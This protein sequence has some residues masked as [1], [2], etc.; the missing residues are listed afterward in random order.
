M[1]IEKLFKKRYIKEHI[2]LPSKR[3]LYTIVSNEEYW[4]EPNINFCS[5]KGYY[6]KHKNGKGICNHLKLLALINDNMIET[7]KFTDEE[8][9]IF[10]YILI[11]DITRYALKTHLNN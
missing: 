3:R 2:F 6:F 11:K 1:K 4:I 7:V 5:C 9:N 8:Y 10:L